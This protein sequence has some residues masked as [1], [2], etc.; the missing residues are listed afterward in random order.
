MIL[1]YQNIFKKSIHYL[2][3]IKILMILTVDV[4]N[5][6]LKPLFLRGYPL[7]FFVFVKRG[8]Q[9]IVNI[10]KYLQILLI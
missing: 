3:K 8:A 4:G 1:V 10:L 7:A 9:K 5:T 6:K 2:P